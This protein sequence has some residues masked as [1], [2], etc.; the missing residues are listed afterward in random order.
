MQC[1]VY[2]SLRQFDYYL[3]VRREDALSRVPE[4]LKQLLGTLEKVVDLE[5]DSTRTLAQADV[6]EVMQQIAV[7]GYYLQMPQRMGKDQPLA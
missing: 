2:K 7:Q 5:L 3:F 1:V 6:V 4:G